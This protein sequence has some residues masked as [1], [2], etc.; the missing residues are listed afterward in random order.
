[1]MHEGIE[2]ITIHGHSVRDFVKD[3][4]YYPAR[5]QN[6]FPICFKQNICQLGI[7]SSLIPRTI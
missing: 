4:W 7:I 5:T 6:K 3:F 1:M 2:I